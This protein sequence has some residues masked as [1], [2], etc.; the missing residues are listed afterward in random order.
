MHRR[1]FWVRAERNFFSHPSR[2]SR[3]PLRDSEAAVTMTTNLRRS[4]FFGPGESEPKL[5]R[6]AGAYPRVLLVA[7][8]D[9]QSAVVGLLHP[10][11]VEEVEN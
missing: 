1:I 8:S 10:D 7:L 6:V 2:K 11:P 9:T 3:I 5:F 4:V